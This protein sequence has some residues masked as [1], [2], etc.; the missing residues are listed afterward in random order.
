MLNS[1]IHRR[2]LF[3]QQ[4]IEFLDNILF[5][6][7]YIKTGV[8]AT[9]KTRTEIKFSLNNYKSATYI[10][11]NSNSPCQ[12]LFNQIN[13]SRT[14]YSSGNTLAIRNG[15]TDANV[16]IA[17]YND[18]VYTLD[19]S[20]ASKLNVST[21][22]AVEQMYV[23]GTNSR[24]TW[25]SGRPNFNLYY[26]K[27]WENGVLIRHFVGAIIRGKECIYDLVEEKAYPFFYA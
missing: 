17:K 26:M 25:Y 4:Q 14:R 2:R 23:G 1:I 13:Y 12:E 5:K 24:D 18:G 11:G 21:Y 8:F 16:H 20:S 15:I 10:F 6:N 7:R 9:N 22:T 27:I 3:A 19:G